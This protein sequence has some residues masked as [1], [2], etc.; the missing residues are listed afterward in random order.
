MAP[1]SI[2]HPVAVLE[3]PMRNCQ[4]LTSPVTQKSAFRCSSQQQ[5]HVMAGFPST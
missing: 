1:H 5:Q 4:V 2:A 3:D